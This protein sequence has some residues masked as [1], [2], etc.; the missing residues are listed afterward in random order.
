MQNQIFV[1]ELLKP[2]ALELN[3]KLEDIIY[4]KSCDDEYVSLRYKDGTR[5]RV[6]VSYGTQWFITN[7]V[8]K[9]LY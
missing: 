1:N 3:H 5:R 6:N 2:L 8:M 4:S 7:S 9:N